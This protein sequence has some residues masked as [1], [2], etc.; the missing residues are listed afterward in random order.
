MLL[1]DHTALRLVFLNA[2]AGAQSS[3]TD[4][5]SGIAQELVEQ[6][7]PAV[8]AMRT[9]ITDAAVGPLAQEFYEALADGYP[10]DAALAQARKSV[11]LVAGTWPGEWATPV[12][13]SRSEGNQLLDLSWVEAAPISTG[14]WFEPETVLIPGGAFVMGRQS[15]EGIPE[16]ETPR[17]N[18]TLPGYLISKEPVSN[19]QYAE[20]IHR[21]GR[22][23]PIEA[24]WD[25][26]S[27]PFNGLDQP[28][29][30]ISFY[31]AVAYCEWLSQATG[32]SYSLP[33]EAEW[34]KAAGQRS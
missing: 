19:R 7:V 32:R 34:E 8:L 29:T 14:K 30:G 3:R 33:S 22:L 23:V 18:V 31:D 17:H 26:Q 11:S 25:G 9:A 15:G 10:I 24:L 6:G 27:P 12:L 28:I 5:F 20:F 13:F 4:T 16:Y 2:C 21:T 1:H